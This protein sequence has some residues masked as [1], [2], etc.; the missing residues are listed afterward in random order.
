MATPFQVRL[1]ADVNALYIR[2]TDRP[3]ARTVEIEEMVLLDL[4]NRGEPVGVEFV[5]ADGFVPFVRRHGGTFD[6][7]AKVA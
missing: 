7:P 6:L 1:D 4:D 5:D 2:L 3:V